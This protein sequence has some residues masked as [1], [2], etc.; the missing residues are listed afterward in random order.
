MTG[1]K[2]I[3]KFIDLKVYNK[4]AVCPKCGGNCASVKAMQRDDFGVNTI[5]FKC[6][7]WETIMKRVCVT[8][9]Y[10]WYE[11]PLDDNNDFSGLCNI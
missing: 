9:G 7:S 6:C 2:Y 11:K 3:T 4:G 1:D 5:P 8:C 10:S